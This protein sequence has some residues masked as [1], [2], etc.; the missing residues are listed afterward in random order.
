MQFP[1][2]RKVPHFIW[3]SCDMQLWQIWTSDHPLFISPGLYSMSGICWLPTNTQKH[4]ALHKH[5]QTPT[6]LLLYKLGALKFCALKLKQPLRFL[7]QMW[8]QTPPALA[9]LFVTQLRIVVYGTLWESFFFF[10]QIMD[11]STYTLTHAHIC[12]SWV[13]GT[14]W[15]SHSANCHHS[16]RS[17]SSSNTAYISHN[18]KSGECGTAYVCVFKVVNNICFNLSDNYPIINPLVVIFTPYVTPVPSGWPDV[19]LDRIAT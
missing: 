19:L 14:R 15:R 17:S 12:W 18:N 11:T 6:R 9:K 2:F 8:R 1:L 10:T 4:I 7:I 16:E 5:M 13:K 3:Q